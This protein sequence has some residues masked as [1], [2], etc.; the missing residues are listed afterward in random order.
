METSNENLNETQ[1][2]GREGVYQLVTQAEYC[3]P[4]VGGISSYAGPNS[5]LVG[6]GAASNTGS[7]HAGQ[8][9][10]AAGGASSA[11]SGA[12]SIAGTS[13]ATNQ[14]GGG[15]P[16]VPIKIS[17]TKV[18]TMMINPGASPITSTTSTFAKV[19]MFCLVV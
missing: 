8:D 1:L 5:M 11:N 15:V 6:G 7:G 9:G 18:A 16:L 19:T 14:G 17:F 4:K 3:R 12:G 10:A 13:G 2:F